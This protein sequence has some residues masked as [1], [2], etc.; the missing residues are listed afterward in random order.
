MS[1]FKNNFKCKVK[2]K[3]KVKEQELSQMTLKIDIKMI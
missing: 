1:L 3:P 2:K